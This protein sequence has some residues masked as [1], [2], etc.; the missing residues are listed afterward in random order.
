MGGGQSQAAAHPVDTYSK[1]G[2]TWREFI[3]ETTNEPYWHNEESGDTMFEMPGLVKLVKMERDRHRAFP[4]ENMDVEDQKAL[5]QADRK[6]SIR[7]LETVEKL[8]KSTEDETKIETSTANA[9]E[10]LVQTQRRGPMQ[11][12]LAKTQLYRINL[13]RGS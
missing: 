10:E 4:R 2:Q 6:A 1:N 3:D 8:V 13:P 12:M 9:I 11:R 7:R 5:A